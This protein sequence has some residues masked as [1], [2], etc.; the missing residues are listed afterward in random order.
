MARLSDVTGAASAVAAVV[1]RPRVGPSRAATTTGR[2]T[3]VVLGTVA[4]ACR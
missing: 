1:V 3:G 2:A 4:S